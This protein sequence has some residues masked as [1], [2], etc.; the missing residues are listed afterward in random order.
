MSDYFDAVVVGSGPAGAT[1]ARRLALKG[2]RVLILDRAKLP[3]HKACGGGLTGNVRRFLDFDPGDVVENAI[4]RTCFVFRGKSTVMLQPNGLHVEM[5]QR[6]RFD[7]LLARKAIEA[8]AELRDETGFKRMER[9]NGVIKV[10]T[11]SGTLTAGVVIGADGAASTVSRAAGLRIGATLGSAIDVD[12]VPRDGIFEKWK[13]TAIF[14]FGVVPRGYGWSFPKGDF[15][16]VGVGAAKKHFPDAKAQLQAFLDRHD[17]LAS[18]KSTVMRAAPLPFWT[19]HE[20]LA[21][22]GVFLVGDAAGLV[23]PLSGEG[24]SYAV[25]SGVISADFADAYLSGDRAADRGYSDRID[26]EISQGLAFAHRLS[27]IFFRYP[28]LCQTIG[29][30]SQYVLDLFA[31]MLAGQIT[32]VELYHELKVSPVGKAYRVLKPVLKIMSRSARGSV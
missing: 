10:T 13:S 28:R 30:R 20:P 11:S 22:D 24:I 32:Y 29:V 9:A 18:P 4:E 14:D 27:E 19:H 8:G 7:Y 15:F 16:S 5:V 31:R 1:S 23:D 6:D 2:R 21:S 26:E 25:H 12:L 17:C 3:R